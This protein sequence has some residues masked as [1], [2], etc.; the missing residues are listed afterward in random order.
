M[1]TTN[2][3]TQGVGRAHGALLQRS[4]IEVQCCPYVG[5]HPEQAP[6]PAPTYMLML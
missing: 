4:K 3:Q 6:G 5:L 2:V 1:A